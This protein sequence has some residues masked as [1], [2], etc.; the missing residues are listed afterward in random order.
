MNREIAM[1]ERLENA[2]VMLD[3][4][5]S[6]EK[7]MALHSIDKIISEL[8]TEVFEFEKFVEEQERISQ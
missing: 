8:K 5:A 3:E 7:R 4:G 1:I 2:R 6:D